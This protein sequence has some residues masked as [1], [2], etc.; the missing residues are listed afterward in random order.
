MDVAWIDAISELWKDDK[1]INFTFLQRKY[2]L[3]PFER[4]GTDVST[5]DGGTKERESLLICLTGFGD[6]RD[7]IA[8]KVTANG[9][10]YTGDLT[11][12]CT[13]L[14]VNK[15]EGK[16]FTAAKSWNIKTVT[17]AWLD[18]SIQRG[19]I[20]DEDKFDP[21]LPP[22]EQGVGAWNKDRRRQSL[23]KRSRSDS[24]NE[25]E[26][27]TRK[28]RKTASM[29]MNS[30]RRN[31]WGDILGRAPSR[32]YSFGH[33]HRPVDEGQ[34]EPSANGVHQPLQVKEEGAFAN[35]VFYIHGF[36]SQKAAVLSQT[37]ATLGGSVVFT[38]ENVTKVPND[39]SQQHFLIVPQSSQ[40]D[41]H[42]SAANDNVHIVTEFYIEKCLHNRK[43]FPPSEHV[44]G[45]P[46]PQFPIPGFSGLTI[47]SA[48]F[49]G[50][51]LSQVAR[52]VTQ[53]G[54]HFEE[55]FR[56]STSL[57]VCKSLEAIRKEKLRLAL[58][59]GV[60][61]VS[62]DW[63]W[64]CI[65]TGYNVP[66]EDYIFPEVKNKLPRQQSSSEDDRQKN[67]QTRGPVQRT[68]SE[69]TPR[70][71]HPGTSRPLGAGVD[72]TAFACDSPSRPL[73]DRIARRKIFA[74]ESTTSADFITA[75][76]KLTA[77]KTSDR[78]SD[79]PLTE[80]S[81]AS[82]NKSPSPK[83]AA[84]RQPHRAKSDQSLDKRSADET[85]S[86]NDPHPAKLEET[87]EEAHNAAVVAAA[88]EA[89]VRKAKDAERQALTSKITTLLDSTTG[90][91][92]N[93]ATA[94]SPVGQ[95]T[96][97]GVAAR[98][99]RR[100]ILGRAI[101]NVSNGSSSAD[102]KARG[103][104]TGYGGSDDEADTAAGHA[105]R[106]GSESVGASMGV[107]APP[108]Q[109]TQLEYYDPEAQDAKAA[110]MSRMMGEAP[111]ASA[112]GGSKSASAAVVVGGRRALRKR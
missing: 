13:H 72:E 53:L 95:D 108:P 106:G 5:Q 73:D 8:D 96:Q 17:L 35:C 37:I 10:R 103:V 94:D 19:M 56:K 12:R 86:E 11:R 82:L 78:G 39:A 104:S 83:A 36:S 65:S 99:R 23:G 52:S 33:E 45:R 7:E 57:L 40:P 98:P 2:R 22:E 14:I 112:N 27:A 109:A 51:E 60:P 102:R 42:P 70:A 85:Q 31:M 47:C 111:A 43:F 54:A 91:N 110:L 34:R 16:K 28:L 15:P 4:C 30:Q 75:R 76:T 66:F 6:Q 90:S 67:K 68:H 1:H 101:S 80:L 58:N 81:S 77:D 59:W 44:L 21:L 46:F 97:T 89:A 18:Q 88:T 48:A 105:A 3:R 74:E 87:V 49:T 71:A 50:L 62:A 69:P 29:K 24:S 63:L 9:G 93:N 107:E 55:Q 84:Q 32:E 25:V 100:Q 61:V 79:A 26:M 38:L 41:T 64:E 20:L 92:P